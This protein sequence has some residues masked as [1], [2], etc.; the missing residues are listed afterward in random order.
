MFLKKSGTE[1]ATLFLGSK[2][3]RCPLRIRL[4]VDVAHETTV[5]GLFA[6]S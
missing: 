6:F 2:S 1:S 4:R 3:G 5:K